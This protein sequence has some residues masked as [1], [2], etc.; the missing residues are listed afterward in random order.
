MII[1]GGSLKES[2]H[3]LDEAKQH[4]QYFQKNSN[5]DEGLKKITAQTCTRLLVVTQHDQL[6][7]ISMARVLRDTFRLLTISLAPI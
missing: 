7:L 1:T 3:A 5:S 2:K 6:N 4:S